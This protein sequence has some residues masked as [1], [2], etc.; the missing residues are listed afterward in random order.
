MPVPWLLLI[1]AMIAV[2]T[3]NGELVGD[4]GK[5][6]GRLQIHKDCFEDAMEYAREQDLD[7]SWIK[8][9]H[10]KNYGVSVF[11]LRMYA[12]RYK[13]KTPEEIC[14]LWNG[15]PDW[16]TAKSKKK[17]NIKRYWL[18]VKKELK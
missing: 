7:V 15:G 11:V 6:L 2:E 9:E 12:A 13:A 1:T 17:C 3:P 5:A 4:N 18:K 8:Y 10:C 16:R 14:K